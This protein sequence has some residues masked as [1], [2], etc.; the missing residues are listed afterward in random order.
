MKNIF[1]KIVS[2]FFLFFSIVS[3]SACS[4]VQRSCTIN[5]SYKDISTMEVVND[6]YVGSTYYLCVEY[7]IG[8]ENSNGYSFISYV[9]A[10]GNIV[11][12][13]IEGQNCTLSGNFIEVKYE[14]KSNAKYTSIYKIDVK[15]KGIS[16]IKFKD[17][18]NLAL[19]HNELK[20]EA[21]EK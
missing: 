4:D 6:I 18:N 21:M 10:N 2:A 12:S 20:L 7:E 16:S 15:S 14:G 1:K 13:Y 3:M 5:Y 19:S 11:I 17:I 9:N 8:N